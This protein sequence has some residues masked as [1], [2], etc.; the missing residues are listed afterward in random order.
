MRY[1]FLGSPEFATKVLDQL[2][3]AGIPPVALVCNP[4]RPAG[5]KKILTPPATKK[6]IQDRGLD[7]K[8][9]QPEN[10]QELTAL[11]P[12][13]TAMANF[14]I[15]AAYGL[16]IPREFIESFKQGII[17]VHPSL[18]PKYRG[19][20]PI[21]SAIL[22]GEERTGVSLFMLDEKVDHGPILAQK[23][24]Y[25]DSQ[26]YNELADELAVLSGNLLAE[27][28]T[29]FDEGK[30]E[31]VEQ[32]HENATLTSKFTTEDAYIPWDDLK[33]AQGGDLVK[34][35]DIFKKVRAFNPEPGAFTFIDNKRIKLLRVEI[36]ESKLILKQ[37]QKEG[38]KPEVI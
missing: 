14:G 19:A 2:I 4:D 12:T 7:I 26:R 13:L 28:L 35:K 3:N 10:K 23:D 33:D 16:I 18:L 29:D 32:N 27:I 34:A 24:L 37:I 5:R 9:F 25:I 6:L 21:R 38:K 8:I 17:G 30:I 22:A 20:S 15:V 36:E 31:P 1:V 11:S